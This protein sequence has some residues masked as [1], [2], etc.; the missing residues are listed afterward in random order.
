MLDDFVELV[1]GQVDGLSAGPVGGQVLK[2]A[3]RMTKGPQVRCVCIISAGLFAL[4]AMLAR[5]G[6]AELS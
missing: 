4:T 2:E 3:F 5:L 1:R 6:W